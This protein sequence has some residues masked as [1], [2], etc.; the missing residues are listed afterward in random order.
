MLKRIH[1]SSGHMTQIAVV[2]DVLHHGRVFEPEVAAIEKPH[3]GRWI[4]TP[5][6][7]EKGQGVAPHFGP[8]TTVQYYVEFPSP[9][10]RFDVRV[11]LAPVKWK[12]K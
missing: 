9:Q 4:V 10:H 12:L 8:H 7:V 2:L 6:D 3:F 5:H 1:Y 11:G